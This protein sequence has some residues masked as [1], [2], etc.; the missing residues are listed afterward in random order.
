MQLIESRGFISETHYVK[1][2]DE[3]I[4]ALHRIVSNVTKTKPVL[5]QHGLLG[6]AADWLINSPKSKYISH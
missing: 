1:T 2:N 6:S 5:L 3:Y 4:L